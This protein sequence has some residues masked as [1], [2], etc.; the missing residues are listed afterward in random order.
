MKRVPKHIKDK[1]Y[2]M[3]ALMNRIIDLNMEVE[4]WAER[5]GVENGFD[6][7]TDIRDDRGYG[8]VWVDEYIKRIEE[9][10]NQ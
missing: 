1:V 4:S 8:I 5:N 2:R 6:L 10:I 3:N 9:A 7:S